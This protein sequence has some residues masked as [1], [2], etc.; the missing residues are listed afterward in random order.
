MRR[1]ERIGH[2]LDD[3][4]PDV[5]DGAHLRLRRWRPGDRAAQVDAVRSSLPHLVPWMPWA[6]GYDDAT[7]RDFLDRATRL[8][9]AHDSFMYAIID[10]AG[11]LVGSCGLHARVGPGGLEIGYWVRS[12]H[13]RRGFATRAA[14]LLTAA[15][16]ALDG[17]D[18]T[19]IHHDRANEPSGRIPRRLGY[20][21]VETVTRAARAPGDAGTA[22]HWRLTADAYPSSPAARMAA[23]EVP[24]LRRS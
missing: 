4:P 19:E 2:W 6:E 5:L 16:F 7:S 17:V 14:A 1:M 13:V 24:A 21:H 23:E 12:S 3:A 20:V 18:R 15:A 22:W 9:D 8:W 11:P 10:P